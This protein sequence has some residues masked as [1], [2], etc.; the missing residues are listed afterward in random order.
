MSDHSL[1]SDED[2]KTEEA[3]R[4]RFAELE[5]EI[6]ETDADAGRGRKDISKENFG[7]S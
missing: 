2:K 7:N 1:P 3:L 6:E 5:E 4:P